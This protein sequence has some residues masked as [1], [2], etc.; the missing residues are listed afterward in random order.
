MGIGVGRVFSSA[1][2]P[3]LLLYYLV[4]RSRKCLEKILFWSG[5]L[6]EKN[7][8][9]ELLFYGV[10]VGLVCFGAVLPMFLLY[11]FFSLPK[12][13]PKNSLDVRSG[14]FGLFSL[15]LFF[16]DVVVLFVFF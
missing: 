15:L 9:S 2:L 16:A 6:F 12:L 14:V 1:V 11:Y 7:F 3:M 5:P 8:G 13:S 4:F 10:G